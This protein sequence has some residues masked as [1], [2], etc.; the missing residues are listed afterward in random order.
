VPHGIRGLDPQAGSGKR[1]LTRQGD[2]LQERCPVP[3]GIGGAGSVGGV[4]QERTDQARE[5]GQGRPRQG[6]RVARPL[7]PQRLF[8]APQ[9][10]GTHPPPTRSPPRVPQ[11]G[12]HQTLPSTRMPAAPRGVPIRALEAVTSLLSSGRPPSSS[13]HTPS[14]HRQQRQVI[15]VGSG[16]PE[17][18]G[19]H[20]GPP[21]ASH[22]S[23]PPQHLAAQGQGDISA[24]SLRH[25][26]SLLPRPPRPPTLPF[27]P[28]P[29]PRAS[30][31]VTPSPPAR[32]A[33]TK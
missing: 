26:R 30:G 19:A 16:A 23:P 7:S 22:A 33:P 15:P 20:W 10:S 28:H 31:P 2:L 21:T 17:A 18:P 24:G 25:N 5:T 32:L 3:H 1:G 8:L 4:R 11:P 9:P 13:F 6:D 29:D 27:L 12:T 14:R